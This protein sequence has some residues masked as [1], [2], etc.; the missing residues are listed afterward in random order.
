MRR[1]IANPKPLKRTIHYRHAFGWLRHQTW[2]AGSD[3]RDEALPSPPATSIVEPEIGIPFRRRIHIFSQCRLT[4]P[5]SR[6]Q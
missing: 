2:T 6:P 3:A 4:K 1:V 5:C